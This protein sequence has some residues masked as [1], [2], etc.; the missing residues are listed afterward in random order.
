MPPSS[1]C[2][3]WGVAEILKGT[4]MAVQRPEAEQRLPESEALGRELEEL[5]V[6]PMQHARQA[7][8]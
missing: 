3:A 4:S 1:A 8:E 7:G 5:D 6:V 2:V